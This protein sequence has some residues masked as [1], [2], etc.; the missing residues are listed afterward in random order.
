V[1]LGVVAVALGAADWV[2]A[3]VIFRLVADVVA[4]PG[5][6]VGVRFKVEGAGFS[7][8]VEFGVVVAALAEMIDA[9]EV[10]A[11]VIT[12]GFDALVPAGTGLIIPSCI[13]LVAIIL[14]Q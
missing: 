12:V 1:E 8:V 2:G 13:L 6:V 14:V 3:A 7:A 9:V 10:E 11:V 4:R 5:V